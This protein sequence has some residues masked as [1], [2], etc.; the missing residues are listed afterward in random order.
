MG[1]RLDRLE[2]EFQDPGLG[3]FRLG[4]VRGSLEELRLGYAMPLPERT[5]CQALWLSP[6][7]GLNREGLTRLGLT[8]RYYDGCFAYEVRWQNILKGQYG[9]ATGQSLSFGLSLR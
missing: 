4:Y 1:Q 9:E 3:T 2:G 6:E 5:C 7:V 8:F